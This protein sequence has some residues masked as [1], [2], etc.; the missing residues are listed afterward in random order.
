MEQGSRQYI[1]TSDAKQS[2][3]QR[4]SL[5]AAALKRGMA[6][7]LPSVADLEKV[8]ISAA[9]LMTTPAATLTSAVSGDALLRGHL[10]WSEENLGWIADWQ[11]DFRRQPH[12]WQF[13]GVT[14]DEAFRRGLGGAARILSGNGE[15]G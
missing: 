9:A 7:A 8:K 14:F 13:R 11:M 15:P 4:D 10:V 12:R 3:L 1:V 2:D 5:L 6:V